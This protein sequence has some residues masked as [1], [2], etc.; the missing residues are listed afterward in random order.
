MYFLEDVALLGE[1]AIL[2]TESRKLFTLFF[3]QPALAFR[4]FRLRVAYPQ[5]ERGR[6]Q[7]ELARYCADGL[8]LVQYQSDGAFFEFLRERASAPS[9][10]LL[11]CHRLR[12]RK[13]SGKADQ[14]QFG[15]S[16]R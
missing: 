12:L 5:T 6:R 2:F 8:A 3:H 4:P 1:D 11:R 9:F 13:V 14:A 15:P 7:V 16:N 10:P